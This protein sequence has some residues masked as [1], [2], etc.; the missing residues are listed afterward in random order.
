MTFIPLSGVNQRT[1]FCSHERQITCLL[2]TAAKDHCLYYFLVF[3]TAHYTPYFKN[4]FPLG[5][6]QSPEEPPLG[7]GSFNAVAG[8]VSPPPFPW[9]P[10]ARH[11]GGGAARGAGLCRGRG[12]AGIPAVAAK[13][14]AHRFKSPLSTWKRRHPWT[15][16]QRVFHA[17]TEFPS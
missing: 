10:L 3:P 1:P 9:K 8:P 7:P 4:I 6:A 11:A 13:A 12:C 2:L 16:Q 14:S 15:L 5:T 17:F